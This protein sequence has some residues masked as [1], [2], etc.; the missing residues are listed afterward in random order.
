VLQVLIGH[1]VPATEARIDLPLSVLQFGD[2][3]PTRCFVGGLIL[4]NDH[5]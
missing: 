5:V 2:A 1:L 4:A 3:R